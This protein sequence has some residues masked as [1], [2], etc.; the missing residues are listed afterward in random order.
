MEQ[1]H[2]E[3][4]PGSE[5]EPEQ[6]FYKFHKQWSKSASI[7]LILVTMLFAGILI[8]FTALNHG[9]KLST[10]NKFW[11][12][13][14]IKYIS[15]ALIQYI[16]GVMVTHGV[17]VNYTRKI[18]H[19]AYFSAPQLLDTMIIPFQ[20][21][22]YTELWNICIILLL[23]PM[24]LKVIRSR[25]AVLRTMYSAIDRPEDRPYTTFWFIS[26]LFMSVPIIS[27]F[28]ILFSYW[29]LED[30]VFIPMIILG[31]G[32]GLA[33]PIG[34]RFG[35]HPYTVSSLFVGRKYTRTLEGSACVFIFSVASVLIFY[36]LFSK[37][38]IVYT[39]LSLMILMPI[40]EAKSPHAWDNPM[41]LLAGYLILI[42][43]RYLNLE[44]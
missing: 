35:K 33:E 43:S 10:L 12:N 21:N 13:Q 9:I 32:D 41:I 7:A 17:K 5:Q 1:E 38:S 44:P 42:G 27:G 30:F 11:L 4:D 18:V 15:I 6:W 26:Q 31:L 19:I 8:I 22:I 2:I 40:V 29:D 23:L 25:V 34:I 37:A 24:L 39:L 20:K 3:H 16:C 14:G 28:S 36:D